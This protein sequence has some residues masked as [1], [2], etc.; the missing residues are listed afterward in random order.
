MPPT[1]PLIQIEE[2]LQQLQEQLKQSRDEAEVKANATLLDQLK[3]HLA[4]RD[5]LIE[6]KNILIAGLDT[7]LREGRRQEMIASAQMDASEDATIRRLLKRHNYVHTL[8]TFEDET[9]LVAR[10]TSSGK[11]SRFVH[12][13]LEGSPDSIGPWRE[14]HSWTAGS[15]RR[16]HDEPWLGYDEGPAPVDS[17]RFVELDAASEL[18]AT[19]R[20]KCK[21]LTSATQSPEAL[22]HAR[23]LHARTL[24]IESTLSV[25]LVEFDRRDAE[26]EAVLALEALLPEFKRAA[27]AGLTVALGVTACR[28]DGAWRAM[29]TRCRVACGD[30]FLSPHDGYVVGSTR[31]LLAGWADRED[32]ESQ[33]GFST[34]LGASLGAKLLGLLRERMPSGAVE[35]MDD[36]LSEAAAAAAARAAVTPAVTG[37]AAMRGRLR[38]NTAWARKA[39]SAGKSVGPIR[40]LFSVL[41][42]SDW[43]AAEPERSST[44]ASRP[45]VPS[46]L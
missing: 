11:R 34:R 23:V 24:P 45:V 38:P 44:R 19:V 20:E 39:A 17:T 28:N 5:A 31:I 8:R 42:R 35:L 32:E 2:L 30:Q 1:A 40:I 4:Q 33:L 15:S 16:F 14:P 27:A 26:R 7:K 12:A 25:G 9:A 10:A 36:A 18:A 6:A 29:I 37:Y 46:S 43:A 13:E 3:A 41:R 21:I 22:T